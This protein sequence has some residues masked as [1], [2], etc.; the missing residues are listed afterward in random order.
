VNAYFDTSALAKR[1]V[2]EP[3]SEGIIDLWR[4]STAIFTSAVTYA[5]M[6]ASLHRK[7]REVVVSAK[8]FERLLV[9]F[10]E[11]W[12]SLYCIEV[13]GGLHLPI[14]RLVAAHPLR[15]FDAIHLASAVLVYQ[16]IP[17]D[18]VFACFDQQLLHAARREGLP[19]FPES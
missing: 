3:G 4:A 5:E 9:S 12:R 1:Y 13:S 2:R 10:R 16:K 18:F 15:G 17:T 14:D 6:M 7:R 11:D 19:T 8:T